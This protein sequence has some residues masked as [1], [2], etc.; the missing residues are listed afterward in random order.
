V[1]QAYIDDDVLEIP[2]DD[3]AQLSG[4]FLTSQAEPP[5]DRPLAHRTH[6]SYQ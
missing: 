5:R 3:P 2:L 6:P 4:R 1:N